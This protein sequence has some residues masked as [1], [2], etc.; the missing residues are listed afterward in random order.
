[1]DGWANTQDFWS[2]FSYCI[3]VSPQS[4]REVLGTEDNEQ[5]CQ[6]HANKS[7]DHVESSDLEVD[8]TSDEDG[9]ASE[10]S[11]G[12]I[13]DTP[14]NHCEGIILGYH[15]VD[16]PNQFIV[17]KELFI[18]LNSEQ[19]IYIHIAKRNDWG[20]IWISGIIHFK[21]IV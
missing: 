14:Q 18:L 13:I 17:K 20:I 4:E 11:K 8:M 15:C 21:Y 9:T 6:K 5:A 2:L 7:D 12:E 16:I 3:T 1:M 19:Y 10:S